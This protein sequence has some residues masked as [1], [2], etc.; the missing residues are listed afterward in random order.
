MCS[1]ICFRKAF[2]NCCNEEE[3]FI[4]NGSGFQYCGAEKEELL[5]ASWVFKFGIV[6]KY[7]LIERRFLF[8]SYMWIKYDKYKGALWFKHWYTSVKSRYLENSLTGRQFR[9]LRAGVIWF[10][11][12]DFVIILAPKFWIFWSFLKSFS[13]RPK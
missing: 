5:L 10:L 7:L 6:S 3:V 4:I 11:L 8:G 13:G 9:D 12:G 1:K 2:L